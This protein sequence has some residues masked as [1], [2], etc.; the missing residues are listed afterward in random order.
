MS[1]ALKTP[2]S[3]PSEPSGQTE[4][5]KQLF[6]RMER[7]KARRW[8][9]FKPFRRFLLID[10]AVFVLLI[11]LIFGISYREPATLENTR[12]AAGRCILVERKATHG[13]KS[14]NFRYVFEL[15][16]GTSCWLWSSEV[17]EDVDELRAEL[18]GSEVTIRY[19]VFNG[20]VIDSLESPSRVYLRM[21]DSNRRARETFIGMFSLLCAG[22]LLFALVPPFSRYPFGASNEIRRLKRQIRK[23]LQ[24]DR[25]G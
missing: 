19:R 1:R 15:E 23:C 10:L 20:N 25:A 2:D 11:P 16:N 6:E 14:V 4:R 17:D 22:A 9:A 13:Y 3:E 7:A 5:I 21:E 18:V 24:Q 12:I 8:A